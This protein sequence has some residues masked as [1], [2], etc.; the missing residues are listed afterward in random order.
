[1]KAQGIV[2]PQ[3]KNA[4]I[5]R[6]VESPAELSERLDALKGNDYHLDMTFDQMMFFR[7]LTELSNYKTPIEGLFLTGAGT[8]PNESISE[9][10]D[11]NCARVFT[12]GSAAI[13]TNL[14]RSWKCA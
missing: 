10:P 5:V 4:I 2:I 12:T 11:R 7:S 9:M 8:H 3:L 1:M 6:H 13:E 14:G